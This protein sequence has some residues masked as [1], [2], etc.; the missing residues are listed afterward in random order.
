MLE[1]PL[2]E[3]HLVAHRRP[4]ISPFQL[5]KRH[6]LLI[7]KRNITETVGQIAKGE[8]IGGVLEDV[9]DQDFNGNMITT[10]RYTNGAF[11]NYDVLK[12][13]GASV[14]LLPFPGA[15]P[16]CYCETGYYL[17][18]V[19]DLEKDILFATPLGVDDLAESADPLTE[20]T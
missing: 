14:G 13:F 9:Y 7:E 3:R 11:W 12:G 15:K 17:V 5:G 6:D 19:T 16:M 10:H 18:R 4:N 2:D 1:I 8:M 20:Y